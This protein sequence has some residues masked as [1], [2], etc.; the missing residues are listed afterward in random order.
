SLSDLRDFEQRARVGMQIE[1]AEIG[2]RI[3]LQGTTGDN[4][5]HCEEALHKGLTICAFLA[6]RAPLHLTFVTQLARLRRRPTL[7]GASR[8]RQTKSLT[9]LRPR[10]VRVVN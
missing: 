7:P 8:L 2:K 6:C 4:R 10:H 3:G 5:Q 9:N 1:I